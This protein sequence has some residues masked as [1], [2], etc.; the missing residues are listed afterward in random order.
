MHAAVKHKGQP[1]VIL[2]KTIKGY[3]MGE[4]GEAQNIT[5]QQKKMAHRGDPQASATASTSRSPTTSSRTCR[6]SRSPKA[7]PRWSTCASGAMELGGYLPPRRRKAEPLEVPRARRRSS[8]SEEHRRARDLDHDGVR[9]D[10]ADADPR[11]EHRQARRADRARRVAHVRHGR[12]VP[13][14][15][16]LLAAGPALQAART[17]TS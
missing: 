1:T 13:P 12:H 3:G 4:A 5:H 10:P 11:Q 9:A 15:R 16:H 8:A 6:T 7:R 2:A 14:A 17:P